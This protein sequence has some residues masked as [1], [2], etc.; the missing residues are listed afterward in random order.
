VAADYLRMRI[1]I[2]E[3]EM[4]TVVFLDSAH[5]LIAIKEMFRGTVSQTSV[6]AREIIKEA[7]AVNAGAV[8]LAHNHPSGKPEPSRADRLLTHSL[9][10]ALAMVEVRVLDH[11]VITSGRIVSFAQR[12]LL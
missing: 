8:I 5:R 10:H 4:F 6:H 7:L 1:G 3:Y 2:L 11:L 12:G 9:V